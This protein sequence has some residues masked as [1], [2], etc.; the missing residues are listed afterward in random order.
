M[1]INERKRLQRSTSVSFVKLHEPTLKKLGLNERQIKAVM[2]VKQKDKIT[3]KEYQ[4]INHTT[5]ETSKRDLEVLVNKDV[6]K[7]RGKGRNVYSELAQDW[8][9]IGSIEK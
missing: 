9:K 3:N 2:Y 5:R 8:V 7:R 4:Q 6:L 1:L